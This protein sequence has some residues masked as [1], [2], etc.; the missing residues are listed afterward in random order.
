MRRVHRV[1]G[2]RQRAMFATGP[3]VRKY[4]ALSMLADVELELLDLTREGVAAPTEPL[5]GLQAMAGGM[6]ERAQDERALEFLFQPV[7]DRAFAARERPSELAIERLLPVAFFVRA[8]CSRT[9]LRRQVRS[10][11]AL[12]GAHHGQP[13]AYVLELTDITGK[14]K[15]G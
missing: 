6:R 14:R 9:Q 7:A 2:E 11:D 4:R 13:V 3:L 10:L 15:P 8:C 1:C 12:T 5:R